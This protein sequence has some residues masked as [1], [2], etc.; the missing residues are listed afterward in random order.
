MPNRM[1]A[2]VLLLRLRQAACDNRLLLSQA[3]AGQAAVIGLAAARRMAS[4]MRDDLLRRLRQGD[5][6]VEC[7]DVLEEP[8]ATA[9][10]HLFCGACLRPRVDEAATGPAERDMMYC[11]AL[12]NAPVAAADVISAS[13]LATA[14]G[15]S[16]EAPGGGA[17]ASGTPNP[18][19]PLGDAQEHDDAPLIVPVVSSCLPIS[20]SSDS[21]V[22][23]V[24]APLPVDGL[25]T[26]LRAL[27]RILDDIRMKGAPC[28][29]TH[30]M[31]VLTCGRW[32]HVAHHVHMCVCVHQCEAQA[33]VQPA[34]AVCLAAGR[35]TAVVLGRQAV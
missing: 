33:A 3:P 21:E 16:L 25:S 32:A 5:V 31:M 2:L 28:D 9:C 13:A 17:G 4:A 22:A 20:E 15:V 24:E 1:N 14:S 27:L 34:P 23:T 18:E 10:G 7:G 29:M 11:C 26:K 30:I 6:C 19:A 35:A 12:C 8:L